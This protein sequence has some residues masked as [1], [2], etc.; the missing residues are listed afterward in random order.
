MQAL[1]GDE[2]RQD[3]AAADPRKDREA[4]GSRRDRRGVEHRH[5]RMRIV[6]LARSRPPALR[7]VI[8][9]AH[10]AKPRFQ[11]L[12]ESWTRDH[13]DKVSVSPEMATF[14]TC[15]RNV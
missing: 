14:S 10:A 15:E 9:R 4:V 3:L 1:G 8:G 7:E 2:E 11:K 6:R 13:S 12:S 5:E